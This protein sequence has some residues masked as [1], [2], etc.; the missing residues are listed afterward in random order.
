[1]PVGIGDLQENVWTAPNGGPVL[2]VSRADAWSELNNP[3]KLGR[4][5]V[6]S[7]VSSSADPTD[8]VQQFLDRP[9][10]PKRIYRCI[11]PL[12]RMRP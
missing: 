9:A 8:V 3:L 4:F 10:A 1:M 2:L 5:R 7:H 6:R 12:C 11:A